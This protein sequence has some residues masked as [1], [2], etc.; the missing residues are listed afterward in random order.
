MS[1]VHP[2][3]T[4]YHQLCCMKCIMF[5][6]GSGI[7]CR[8]AWRRGLKER[9]CAQRELCR[10]VAHAICR[11]RVRLMMCPLPWSVSVSNVAA[12]RRDWYEFTL[13][14]AIASKV[15]SD[16]LVAKGAR[17]H[18]LP[19]RVQFTSRLTPT[20]LGLGFFLHPST[21][22]VHMYGVSITS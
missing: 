6:S 1:A 10:S 14:D 2:F 15:G 17:V 3:R 7:R 19:R 4:S 22:L 21:L 16:W 8:W 18:V 12:L 20:Y 13:V 5:R 11:W 9:M